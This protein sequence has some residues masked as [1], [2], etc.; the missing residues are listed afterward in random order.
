MFYEGTD[1][2]YLDR[3][4]EDETKCSGLSFVFI[5]YG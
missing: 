3:K 4:E 2:V 5:K 1:I